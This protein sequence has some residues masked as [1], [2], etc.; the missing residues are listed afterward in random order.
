MSPMSSMQSGIAEDSQAR[1]RAIRGWP[2]SI[3]AF[4]I[5]CVILISVPLSIGRRADRHSHRRGVLARGA[6]GASRYAIG[7]SCIS[8]GLGIGMLFTLFAVP[9]YMLIGATHSEE[10]TE[11]HR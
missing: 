11:A 5:R 8:T 4:A 3:R 6:G 9:A 7:D 10:R 1:S 2:R